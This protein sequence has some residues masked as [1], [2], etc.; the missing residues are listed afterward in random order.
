MHDRIWANRVS[1]FAKNCLM[2]PCRSMFN[3]LD[4]SHLSSTQKRQTYT[5]RWR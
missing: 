3:Y 2:K 1:F 5:K 4:W